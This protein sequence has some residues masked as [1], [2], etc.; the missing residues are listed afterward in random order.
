[1]ASLEEGLQ[2]RSV[3]IDKLSYSFY[4]HNGGGDPLP[5]IN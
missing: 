2:R 3:L 4:L 1:M 5:R